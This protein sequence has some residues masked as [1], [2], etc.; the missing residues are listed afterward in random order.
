VLAAGLPLYFLNE[1]RTPG[2]AQVISINVNAV[3]FLEISGRRRRTPPQSN[4]PSRFMA[5]SGLANRV[6]SCGLGAIASARIR[7]P[8]GISSRNGDLNEFFTMWLLYVFC[9]V[10]S[11]Y[12][13]YRYG[14]NS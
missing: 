5:S 7:T 4:G 9:G 3:G 6:E 11:Q 13:L 10:M 2:L 8:V 1:T 12:I 14:V